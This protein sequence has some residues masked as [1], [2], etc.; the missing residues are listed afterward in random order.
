V[1]GGVDKSYGVHVGEMA[2]LPKAVVKRAWEVLGEL[3]SGSRAVPQLEAGKRRSKKEAVSQLSLFGQK[4]AVEEE[5]HKLDIDS[6]S[7]LEALNKLYE[8]KKKAGEGKVYS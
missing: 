3:E 4:S 8:L 1:P 2:G 6:L 5:L 7:P